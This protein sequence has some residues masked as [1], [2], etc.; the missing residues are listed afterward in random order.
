MSVNSPT[1]LAKLAGQVQ[2]ALERADDPAFLTSVLTSRALRVARLRNDWL[3]IMTLQAELRTARDA[4]AKQRV[5]EEVGPHLG[6]EQL[7]VAWNRVLEAYIARR[8]RGDGEVLGESVA[9]L[10]VSAEGLQRQ[11][12]DLQAEIVSNPGVGDQLGVIR[13]NLANAA[14]ERRRVLTRIRQRVMDYLSEVERQIV[15]GEVSAD[16]FERNRRYVDERLSVVAPQALEQFAAA[17]RRAAEGDTEARSHALASCRRVLKSLAD[18]VCPATGET[19]V[20]LD[21]RE[22]ILSDDKFMNRLLH[23][24]QLRLERSAL[25]ELL[26]VRLQEIGERLRR[27][28]DLASKGV[29]AAVTS[30]EVDQCLIQTY[31]LVGDILRLTDG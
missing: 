23:F 8:S 12:D 27:L 22:R 28:N 9:E 26:K 5:V 30:S 16:I 19:V 7:E 13:A 29:H 17:Y 6:E 3:T 11:A 14:S 25:G 10:E 18:A 4:D 2:D 1:A 31:L 15:F 20:G 24:V 21:G